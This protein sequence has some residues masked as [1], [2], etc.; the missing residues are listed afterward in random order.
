[1]DN[2]YKDIAYDEEVLN[3]CITNRNSEIRKLNILQG[4]SSNMS[5]TSTAAK[6]LLESGDSNMSST[7]GASRRRFND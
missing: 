5:S 2:W 6:R 4:G 7:S 3:D 1:M